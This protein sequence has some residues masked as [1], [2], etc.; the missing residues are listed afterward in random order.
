MRR[1]LKLPESQ[2]RGFERIHL[3]PGE[4]QKVSHILRPNDLALLDKQLNWMFE[5]GT[6]KVMAG[7]S[8]TA[9]DL[10]GEFQILG[11]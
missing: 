6:F 9:I 4:S 5:P 1:I 2:L 7:S 8:S 11:N 3:L 10:T